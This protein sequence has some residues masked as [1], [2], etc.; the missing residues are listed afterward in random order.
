MTKLKNFYIAQPILQEFSF[1]M[2][3]IGIVLICV[4][5]KDARCER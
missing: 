4:G 5:F 1:C 2:L 3:G